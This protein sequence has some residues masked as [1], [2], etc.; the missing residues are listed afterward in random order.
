MKDAGAPQTIAEAI[1]YHPDKKNAQY[2]RNN[3]R[4]LAGMLGPERRSYGLIYEPD[5]YIEKFQPGLS[6]GA[7]AQQRMF[8]RGRNS[9][10]LPDMQLSLGMEATGDE[11]RMTTQMPMG[12]S[13]RTQ[14]GDPQ[15]GISRGIG[16]KMRNQPGGMNTSFRWKN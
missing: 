2:Q 9:P 3:P 8:Q 5:R 4:N 6:V 10:G 11:L 13:E 12:E 16:Q 1:S 7:G 14:G 15:A